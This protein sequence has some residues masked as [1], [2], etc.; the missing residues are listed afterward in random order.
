M[1]VKCNGTSQR[2]ASGHAPGDFS[3]HQLGRIAQSDRVQFHQDQIP[4]QFFGQISLFPQGKGHI[5]KNGQ[6]GKECTVLKKHPHFSAQLVQT[7]SIEAPNFLAINKN[8]PRFCQK[9][10]A[11][12]TQYRRFARAGP[13]H[14]GNDFSSR[15][16][17][18][19]A[20]EDFAVSITENQIAN[21]DNIGHGIF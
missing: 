13:P 3:R 20:R 14:D 17:H 5:F 12:Q 6:I 9:L 11:D 16:S 19:D 8:L 18:V 1:G 10:A 2:N 21:V 4:D 15:K 7:C